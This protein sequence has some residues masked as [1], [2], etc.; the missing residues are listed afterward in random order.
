M[1][2]TK[3]WKRKSD[4]SSTQAGKKQNEK[5]LPLINEML[6][7]EMLEKVF[8][9]LAPKDLKTAMLVCNL[10]KS[11]ASSSPALWSWVKF[12]H[13][14]HSSLDSLLKTMGMERLRNV[15]H[16]RI[17]T[18]LSEVSWRRLLEAALQH[19]GLKTVTFPLYEPFAF[20]GDTDLLSKF[21]AK[22]EEVESPTFPIPALASV[23]QGPNNLKKLWVEYIEGEDRSVVARDLNKIEHLDLGEMKSEDV[24][25]LLKE[26]QDETSAVTS[27][28]ICS[29]WSG[30]SFES[31]PGAFEKVEELVLRFYDEDNP[32]GYVPPRAMNTLCEA[33]STSPR[34][35]KL[36]IDWMNLSKVE[37]QLL[38]RMVNKMEEATL[39]LDKLKIHQVEAILTHAVRETSLKMLWL[40]YCP[41]NDPDI[42]LAPGLVSAAKK[43]IPKVNIDC[44]DSDESD[45]E[46]D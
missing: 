9:H 44:D 14:E 5:S 30:A 23:L 22:M 41:S 28:S 8:S 31:F 39:L 26:M 40:N 11:T 6:P 42:D 43:V 34:L 10:W 45:N 18:S 21:L 29:N 1:D 27:L 33:I 35:K 4:E 16:L 20:P 38:A 15:K 46:S 19:P 7:G 24:E 25:L 17:Q 32:I 13:R 36:T 12:M 2:R 37:P 3:C